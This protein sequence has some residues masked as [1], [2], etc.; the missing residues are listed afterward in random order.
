MI[1]KATREQLVRFYRDWYR[2][3][4]MAVIVVG[5]VDRNAVAAMIRERFATLAN[6]SPARPRPVFDVPD[7][8][9]TRYAIVTDKEATA[10][11]VRLS[12]LPPARS[13]GTVGGYRDIIRDQLFAAMLDARLDELSQGA[14]PPFIR[15]A[16][17]RSLFDSPRTRDEAVLQAM[18]ANGGVARGLDALVT[19]LQRV[20]RFDS[21]PPSSTA[22]GARGWPAT[23][24]R[25]PRAPTASP[26]AG[27]TST[28]N[29]LQ[30][31]SLP[32][33]GRSSRSTDGS[34]RR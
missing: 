23:S 6:P 2:P 3:D 1:E 33:I 26:R 30:G 25:S 28:R 24:A 18:V 20:G 11:M 16:A 19:E 8:P 12:A 9:A 15:A 10:T 17:D 29:F 32:T 34:C 14:S 4:L 22:P 31:E 7:H 27:P 13:Q 5:D 21:R